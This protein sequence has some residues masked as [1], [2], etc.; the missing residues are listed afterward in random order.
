M[1]L[2]GLDDESVGVEAIRT[3]AQDYLVKGRVDTGTL[4]RAIGY[5]TERM[6]HAIERDRLMTE[7]RIARDELELRVDERTADLKRTVER[8]RVEGLARMQAED[9]KARLQ[10]QLYQAQ[11]MEAV[12]Q[13]AAG[14][15][16][17][18]GN[19]Q[20]TILGLASRARG[21]LEDPQKMLA[22]LQAI[23]DTA[24][25]AGGIVHS[26]LTFNCEAEVRRQPVNLCTAVGESVY[27]LR[28]SLPS[29][30]LLES[31][32]CRSPLWVSADPVQLEQVLL[33]LAINARDAM[34]GGGRLEIAASPASDEDAKVF[35][36][37]HRPPA[38]FARLT[39]RDT[40]MGIPPE[41]QSQVF[42]P[43]FTT[44][45]RGQGTGLGLSI[46][47]GIVQSLGGW[48]NLHSESGQGT[49]V[50][51]LLPRIEPPTP[52]GDH[53][54]V[55]TETAATTG[56]RM[57]LLGGG[58]PY[59]RGVLGTM[60]RLLGF[61]VEQAED[62]AGMGALCDVHRHDARL[63]MVDR[64]VLK[65]DVAGCIGHLR[66]LGVSAPVVMLCDEEELDP[67][68]GRRVDL[69]LLRRPFGMADLKEVTDHLGC[70]V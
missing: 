39:V 21:S 44:K 68:D 10:E 23:E 66:D 31:D 32:T 7:L 67:E 51:I 61:D 50:T 27:L 54:P 53:P 38:G 11:K 8:L 37:D 12:G 59:E 4:A 30:V 57:V 52:N 34:P 15:G 9:A 47:H 24:R 1:V 40:G 36:A 19:V 60:L 64:S 3:G 20:A 58:T 43:Y 42:D 49:T 29:T 55:L 13:L 56:G 25:Q 6:R 17:D 62:W 5:A 35:Q 48:I 41:I 28:H 2:T 18:F 16:H 46:V 65:E 45:P 33:N 26:L 69:R 70:G 14:L 22:T 63:I